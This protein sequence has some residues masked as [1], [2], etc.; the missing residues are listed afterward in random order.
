MQPFHNP[1]DNGRAAQ[2]F[3]LSLLD[4]ETNQDRAFTKY[5]YLDAATDTT[6]AVTYS[7]L[8]PG[9]TYKYFLRRRW[10]IVLEKYFTMP[11]TDA[12]NEI[13]ADSEEE[14]EY[15]TPDGR[16][17]GAKRP[18]TSGVILEKKGCKIRKYINNIQK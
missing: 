5:V 8:V 14:S 4:T 10:P 17:W 6:A 2:I 16:C 3:L 13:S 7:G 11:E 18:N 12:V 1:L 9:R 15:F